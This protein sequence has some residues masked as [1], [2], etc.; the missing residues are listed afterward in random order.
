MYTYVYRE[1]L[2]KSI[3]G[4][5]IFGGTI[6]YIL[7]LY[8]D[9]LVVPH[10]PFGDDPHGTGSIDGSTFKIGEVEAVELVKS[11]E[12]IAKKKFRLLGDSLSETVILTGTS[13]LNDA[14]QL[15]LYNKVGLDNNLVIKLTAHNS[16]SQFSY[17][18][19]KLVIGNVFE[20]SSQYFFEI[21]SPNSSWIDNCTGN[22]LRY[23]EAFIQNLTFLDSETEERTLIEMADNVDHLTDL[24]GEMNQHM[25]DELINIGT[26]HVS[27]NAWSYLNSINQPLGKTSNVEFN[28]VTVVND[29]IV[30]G[31]L[32]LDSVAITNECSSEYYKEN[33]YSVYMGHPEDVRSKFKFKLYTVGNTNR[34]LVYPTDYSLYCRAAYIGRTTI[35]SGRLDIIL[36]PGDAP[37]TKITMETID[38]NDIRLN[39]DGTISGSIGAGCMFYEGYSGSPY[40]YLGIAL[41]NH[42]PSH[43]QGIIDFYS[44]G[45]ALLP[46]WP[47]TYIKFYFNISF[48]NNMDIA[49]PAPES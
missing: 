20:R 44:N 16:P 13:T 3:V 26:S 28:N 11:E 36:S 24:F 37:V 14:G 7:G 30:N 48:F 31:S 8:T 32:S 9:K 45:L 34:T 41:I 38:H 47:S 40:K 17:I 46:A 39:P 4:E 5:K 33:Q 12:V 35:L 27:S 15:E 1:I 42:N 10:N 19:K 22:N 2:D 21:D 23:V 18:N 43:Y 6:D 49:A 29:L 25:A